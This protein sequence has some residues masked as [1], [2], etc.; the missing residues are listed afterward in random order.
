MRPTGVEPAADSRPSRWQRA[1]QFGRRCTASFRVWPDYVIIGAQKSG[2]TSLFFYLRDHPHVAYTPVKEVNF[3]TRNFEK[4]PRWYRQH[5]PTAAYLHY[6]RLVLG[7]RLIVGEASPG[8]LAYPHAARR[9]AAMLPYAKLIVMMRNPVERAYSHY[10]HI[11]RQGFEPLSFEA[12]LAE[13]ESRI[14]PELERMHLDEYH[15]PTRYLRYAYRANGIYADQL[16]PWLDAFP[17]EQLLLLQ[18]EAFFADT[19]AAFDQVTRFLGL[20]V[21]QPQAFTPFNQGDYP[22][23]RD[24]TRNRLANYFAP[25]NRRLYELAGADLAWD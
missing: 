23:M 2:T 22:P 20:P 9:L 11:V 17:R 13:E 10:Q 6:N 4:G 7:R 24:E 14:G 18:S 3:F 21:W 5:F 12:A 19:P 1:L 25:H 16:R 15:H 8:Y